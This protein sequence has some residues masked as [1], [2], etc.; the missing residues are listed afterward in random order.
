MSMALWGQTGQSP[1]VS[2]LAGNAALGKGYSGDGGPAN[3]AQ[4]NS[5]HG[6]AV[7]DSGSVFIA[8][9]GNG[10][11][12]KVGVDG[13]IT[14]LARTHRDKPPSHGE[15]DYAFPV[16][17]AVDGK[18]NIYVTDNSDAVWK[19][20]PVREATTLFAGNPLHPG[21][22]GDGGP[23]TS[24]QLNGPKG[25]AVDN[26]GDLYIAECNNRVVRKVDSNGIITTV[27]G[28]QRLLKGYSGDG[29]P[30][31]H[32]ALG[33]PM[34]VAVGNDGTLFIADEGVSLVRKVNSAG[35]IS[36]VAGLYSPA[37]TG[38][39]GDGGP[40]IAARVDGPEALAV[41][42]AGNLYIADTLSSIVRMVDV[43]GNISTITD[44]T[45]ASDKNRTVGVAV[46][47]TGRLFIAYTGKNVVAQLDTK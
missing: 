34:G 38:Y 29:G 31:I 7:D 3:K 22:T 16:G 5:P 43:T 35:I 11:I 19:I 25:L 40:A 15:V 42:R 10:V 28:D 17:I 6:I 1:A 41:D 26:I 13:T 20:D 9:T 21:Y 23:A 4:L 18:G 32:A 47:R 2:I 45:E 46:S 37:N 24:A 14:T 30:A 44:I 8:D 12:R 33:C 27:A 39:K 36:T